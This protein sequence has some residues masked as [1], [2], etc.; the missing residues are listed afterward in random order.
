[1]EIFLSNEKSKFFEGLAVLVAQGQSI[2]SAASQVDCANSTA[3]RI[4][5]TDDFKAEVNRLRS[6]C[7]SDAI[8][9][10]SN[11]CTQ[12]VEVIIDLMQNAQDERIKLRA[13]TS[14]LERFEKLSDHHELRER[15]EALEANDEAN[16]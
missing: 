16:E 15:I 4:A 2:A 12:A 6:E 1:M 3:Y 11:A 5:K 7:V 9:M 14:I 8:G 10:L 13:A